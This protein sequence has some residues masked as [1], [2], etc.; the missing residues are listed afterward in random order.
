MRIPPAVL[1]RPRSVGAV[2]VGAAAGDLALGVLFVSL[3]ISPAVGAVV[4]YKLAGGGMVGLLGAAGGAIAL[5]VGMVLA[6][7]A[8]PSTGGG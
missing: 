5:P 3:M 7:R 4:G 1:S 6:L 2:R 8:L